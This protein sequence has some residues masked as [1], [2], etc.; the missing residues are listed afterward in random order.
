[1]SINRKVE[2]S[3]AVYWVVRWREGGKQRSRAFDRKRDAQV[4]ETEIRRRRQLGDLDQINA[5]N[6]TLADFAREWWSVYAEPNLAPKTQLVYAGLWDRHVL[7]HFGGMEIRR[8]TPELVERYQA[9]LRKNGVGE[10]TIRKALALLQTVLQRAV[11]WRRIPSN[12]VAAIRKPTQRRK[13]IVRPPSPREVEQVRGVLLA[14]GQLADATLISVLAYAGLRPG[15]A[16]GLRWCDVKERVLQIERAV[17]LGEV[18]E[19]KTRQ[20]RSVRLLRPVAEDLADLRASAEADELDP[21]FPSSRGGVW[22]DDDYRNWRRRRFDGALRAAGVEIGRPYDLRHAF[23][24][25]L[26]SEGRSI[27]YVAAQAGHSP[28]MTLDTYGHVIEE[29]EEGEKTSAEDAIYAAR[30]R[31]VPAVF[32]RTPE[33]PKGE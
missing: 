23:V 5:G 17:S 30:D 13:L 19:T 27:V 9:T 26:I 2:R 29:L 22:N 25:L 10:P 21:V 32:P 4:F 1:M 28:T 24:S 16:I 14:N 3:G 20:I 12:P 33:S 8:I 18:K 7:P 31:G 11:V 6:E 15:E